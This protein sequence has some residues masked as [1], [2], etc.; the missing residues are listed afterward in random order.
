MNMYFI[1]I[2]NN[3]ATTKQRMY[4]NL[5]ESCSNLLVG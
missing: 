4:I 1:E 3:E 2:T 5:T